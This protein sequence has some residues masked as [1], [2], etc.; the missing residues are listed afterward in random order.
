MTGPESS[1]DEPSAVVLFDPSGTAHADNALEGL[2][3][4]A[5]KRRVPLVVHAPKAPRSSG[6]LDWI[7]VEVGAT[8]PDRRTQLAHRRA[9]VA[10]IKAAPPG[11][12]VCDL[13]LGR[14]LRSRGPRIP[15]SPRF[16]GIGHQTN[17]I[18]ERA[19]GTR[20]PRQTKN[21]SVLRQLGASGARVV[22]HTDEAARRFGDFMPVENIRRLGWP[23]VATDD[24]CLSAPAPEGDGITL[25][26]AGTA[27]VEKGLAALLRAARAVEGF[28]RLVV[29]GRIA[30]AAMATLDTSDPRLERWDRWLEPEEYF[31]T[32][33]GASL[34][35]LPYRG[36]YLRHGIYSSV[37]GEAMARG[38]PLV[39]TPALG[40]L[41]PPG[42]A[43][44]VVARDESDEA[45]AEALRAAIAGRDELEAA[46]MT[47]GR[48]HVRT[49]HSFEGYLA[50]IIDAGTS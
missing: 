43:G 7:P 9:L 26:F 14:T 37:M 34:V 31:T 1:P 47:A 50:G 22:A 36:K 32:L 46:A 20:K 11:A 15:S 48:A 16:V 2:A 30:P 10:A 44:A 42:Y 12:V 49:H 28:D 35:V 13:G 18:D 25:L 27:R 39:V 45:L 23:V 38:R 40:H 19:D 41:L 33:G 21:Q 17:A 24:P 4:A 29:P 6:T 5:A 3:A 8:L